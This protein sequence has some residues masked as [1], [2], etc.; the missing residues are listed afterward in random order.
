MS[1]KEEQILQINLIN[2][3]K[4]EWPELSD[5]I[6][7]FANERKC[8][9]QQGLHLKRMGVTPGVSD[10][11]LGISADGYHGLWIELKTS[12]GK[13]SDDQIAFIHKKNQR[14]YFA[15]AVW[16]LETA[17]EVIKCYLRNYDRDK[18]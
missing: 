1:L 14:G 2:W 9:F 11:F 18:G 17:Q 10:I 6:H 13:L 8:S 12:K 7:H 15:V 3:F 16:G 5:D 4:Y